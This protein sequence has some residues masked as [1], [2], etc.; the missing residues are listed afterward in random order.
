MTLFITLVPTRTESMLILKP[1]QKKIALKWQ[2]IRAFLQNI[3]IKSLFEYICAGWWF[4]AEVQF[5]P[6]LFIIC[7]SLADFENRG[8]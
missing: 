8:C 2:D 5:Y 7:E 1:K 6:G 3:S 4:G